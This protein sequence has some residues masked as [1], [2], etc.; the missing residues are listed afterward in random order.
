MEVAS[1]DGFGDGAKFGYRGEWIEDACGCCAASRGGFGIADCF[2]R[3][4]VGSAGGCVGR[5]NVESRRTGLAACDRDVSAQGAARTGGAGAI[6]GGAT[7]TVRGGAGGGTSV[8]VC[9]VSGG[10]G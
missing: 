7:G 5:W 3:G 1:A 9:V 10:G 2:D 4:A 6:G 8:F